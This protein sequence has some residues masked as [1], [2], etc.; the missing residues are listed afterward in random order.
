MT[1]YAEALAA[2]KATK[3]WQDSVDPVSLGASIGQQR[4]IENRLLRA[5]NAGWIAALNQAKELATEQP[6]D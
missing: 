1:E 4:F 3:E 2:F 6:S 5:F